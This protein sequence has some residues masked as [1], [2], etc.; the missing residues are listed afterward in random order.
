MVARTPGIVWPALSLYSFGIH[1]AFVPP[2]LLSSEG[3]PDGWSRGNGASIPWWDGSRHRHSPAH[4]C[5]GEG[6]GAGGVHMVAWWR[7]RA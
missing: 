2:F 1:P 7:K 6:A 3:P 4:G 5:R